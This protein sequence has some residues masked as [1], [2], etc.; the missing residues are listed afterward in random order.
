MSEFTDAIKAG[1]AARVAAL[2]DADPSLL[3]VPENNT[4]PLLLA[5]YHGKPDIARLLIDRGAPVSFPEACALGDQARVQELLAA[6]PSALNTRS[7]D[8]FPPMPMAIFFGH[9]A[10]ARWLIEQGADVN[11][12]AENPQR[13]APVHA[14][15][16]TCDRETMR[17]LLERGADPNA[18]QQMDYTPLHGA[19]SRGD[20]EMAQLLL[21]HGADRE[22]KASDG[23]TAGDVARKYGKGEFAEWFEGTYGDEMR[24]PTS[25]Q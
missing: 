5:I 18:R 21:A 22:A 17:L 9:G 19:A 3:T 16:A 12:P 10:L 2:A 15:A 13:V 14:A 23:M 11:A 4:T 20:I 24:R 6:D 1:D 8:G 25:T 7:P